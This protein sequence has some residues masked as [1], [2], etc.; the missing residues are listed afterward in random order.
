MEAG[1]PEIRGIFAADPNRIIPKF[2][3][4]FTC[5]EQD[6]AWAAADEGAAGP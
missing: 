4:N 5:W 6:Q 3:G 2:T 1:T